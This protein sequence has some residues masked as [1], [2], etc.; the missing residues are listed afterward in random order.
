MGSSVIPFSCVTR[1]EGQSH[2]AVSTN[3]NCD[4]P[5]LDITYLL[6][7]F[8]VLLRSSLRMI[9][10]YVTVFLISCHLD[11]HIPSSGAQTSVCS[12]FVWWYH[13]LWS[14]LFFLQQMGVGS[15]T[16]SQVWVCTHKG[17]SGTNKSV[18]ELTQD[19]KK[20][21]RSPCPTSGW[22]PGSSN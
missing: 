21:C 8:F 18:Q 14:L 2:W 10:V 9:L 20:N 17:E 12:I 6:C 19:G 4:Q 5:S 13:W 22:N 15:L 7:L 1:C 16:C 3:D 11:S